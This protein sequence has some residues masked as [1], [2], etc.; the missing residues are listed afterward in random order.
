MVPGSVGKRNTSMGACTLPPKCNAS[1]LSA[2]FLQ[3][4]SCPS[5]LQGEQPNYHNYTEGRLK[6][7]CYLCGTEHLSQLSTRL[8]SGPGIVLYCKHCDIGMLRDAPSNLEKY[9]NEEYHKSHGPR[10]GQLSSYAE[11]FDSYVNYQAQRVELLKPWLKPST[12]LLDVGC[13]TG[14]FLYNIKD[15]VGE[16]VGVDYDSG[17]AAFAA[18]ICNCTTFGGDLNKSGFAPASF[19][20]VCSLQTMEHVDDPIAFAVM[21]GKY[22]KPGGII[23]IEVPSLS[24]P[25]LSVYDV[26]AFRSFY[27]HEAHLFYFNARSLMTVMS[28]AGF[29]GRI[30]FTQDY[31]FLN[32]IHWS[33]KGKPQ[34]SC[35]DGLG[36]PKLPVA[37]A[38]ACSQELLEDLQ[39]WIEASDQQYKAILEKHGAT[40]NISF[41]GK[42]ADG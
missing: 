36:R 25:L 29:T 16:V 32:H 27:F 41:I 38:S 31:N 39:A 5:P 20:V 37:G 1:L 12:R 2:T 11:M 7:K 17:A 21:L 19:D 28:K 10:L 42:M 40:A 26:S 24:D 9:Y 3:T 33:F 4:P 6:M 15:F 23:Y 22:L 14:H 34:S 18:K 30:H 13:Q 8:R 35:H